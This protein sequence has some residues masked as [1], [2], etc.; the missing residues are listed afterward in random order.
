MYNRHGNANHEQVAAI[1]A[2]LEG[3]ERGLLTSAGMG[4]ATTAMLT[5]LK[6]GDHVIGQRS[7]Y[8]GVTSWMLNLMPRF[9]VDDVRRPND[10][11]AFE[12]AFT[13]STSLVLVE[14]PSNPR[15]RSPISPPSR[16]SPSAWRH[17]HLRQHV[18]DADQP[19]PARPRRRSRVH[20][21][22]K[23]LGGHHDVMAGVILATRADRARSG[24][25]AQARAPSSSP[26]DGWLLLRGL[27][28]IV[29]PGRA[30]QRERARAGAGPSRPIARSRSFTIPGSS[31]PAA[32]RSPPAQMT[33]FTGMILAFELRGGYRA[34]DAFMSSA[35]LATRAASLGRFRARSSSIPRRCGRRASPPSSSPR[36]ESPRPRPLR[37]GHRARRRPGRRRALRSRVT[38][39]R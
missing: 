19:A 12:R 34:A 3:A 39:T 31:A 10:I 4:A 17:H 5:L 30:A 1:L 29:A 32:T 9:G 21:A 23:Y 11:D 22:T 18:R 15:W 26:F 28:T 25:V 24:T 7:I 14:T 35:P 13:P 33:G 36:P 27:R 6:A 16:R 20:S 8:A 37:D 38:T 2:E